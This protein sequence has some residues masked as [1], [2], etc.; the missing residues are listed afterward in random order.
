M[1]IIIT[2]NS[3][4][5]FDSRLPE[6]EDILKSAIYKITSTEIEGK[7]KDWSGTEVGNFVVKYKKSR[8]K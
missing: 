3:L 1:K 5:S 8:N 2:I 4:K 6:L 7:I